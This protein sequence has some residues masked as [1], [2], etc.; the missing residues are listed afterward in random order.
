MSTV[1][2]T[3]DNTKNNVYRENSLIAQVFRSRMGWQAPIPRN[4]IETVRG[5]WDGRLS[6]LGKQRK[7]VPQYRV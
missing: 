1:K 3:K 4:Q 2:I 7:I 6:G 5:E